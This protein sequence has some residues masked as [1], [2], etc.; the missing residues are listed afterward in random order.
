MAKDFFGRCLGRVGLVVVTIR[1]LTVFWWWGSYIGRNRIHRPNEE[2]W[3][4]IQYHACQWRTSVLFASQ[5][6]N[7]IAGG[8]GDED[9]SVYFSLAGLFWMNI[10]RNIKGR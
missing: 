8:F 6:V 3:R 4:E 5:R 10:A 9:V 1:S 7:L 2:F